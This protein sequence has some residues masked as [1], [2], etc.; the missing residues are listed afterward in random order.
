MWRHFRTSGFHHNNGPIAWT[1]VPKFVLILGFHSALSIIFY[2]SYTHSQCVFECRCLELP[3]KWRH[4]RTCGLH[5][6][7]GPIAWTQVPK[8]LLI[9]G[10]HS[11]LS[12]IFYFSYTHSWRV[13]VC[14]CLELPGKWRHFRTC[15]LQHKNGPIAWTQV[16]KFVL[17]LGVPLALSTTFYFRT[18]IHFRTYGF[19]YNNSPIA[20]TQ[21]P[22]FVLILGVPLAL[23]TTFY[24]SD[25]HSR[26]V[27]VCRC[28]ELSGKWRHFRTS[29]I[30]HD[31]GPIAWTQVSKSVL[32][33]GVPLAL[34][35][36]FYFRTHIR[37]VYSNAVASNYLESVVISGQLVFTITIAL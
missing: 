28:L 1:Q 10:F 35:T 27:F 16:P 34:S 33:L 2:F 15:G 13:F 36:T 9:L 24:F 14:R 18:H 23:S 29:D 17:I 21:F 5:H 12:I 31:N 4:F 25:K 7:N 11:A 26:R 6:K 19:H 37:N 8:F 30:H 32:I 3:G 22:N 20:W